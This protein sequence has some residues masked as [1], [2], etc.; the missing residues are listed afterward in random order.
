MKTL[1]SQLYGTEQ[2]LRIWSKVEALQE[3]Y[4]DLS[5]RVSKRPSLSE[6]DVVLIAYPDQVSEPGQRPLMTL[7]N[8]LAQW[9][10]R[11]V[12][13]LHLLPIHPYSSDDGFSV[14]D[15][16]TVNPEF[17]T[18][19]DVEALAA[20]YQLML[21]AVINHVSQQS[22]W[23][24]AY[25]RNESPYNQYFI[26]AN[27][28]FEV[29]QVYRARATPLLT[30]IQTSVGERRVWTSF[31][32]DQIDLNYANPEVLLEM[33]DVLLSYVRHGARWLRLDAAGLL[34]KES[35]TSCLHLPQ[36]HAVI[37][38]IRSVLDLSA[39]HVGIVPQIN[40]PWSENVPYL[41]D[42]HNE[43]QMIY[44]YALPVMV[45]HA[46]TFARSTELHEWL[47]TLSLPSDDTY[48]YNFLA[49]HDGISLRP[50]RGLI[51]E[52][53]LAQMLEAAV[54]NGGLINFRK[55]RTGQEVPYEV[56]I[57]YYDA[58][59][60][61]SLPADTAVARFRIAHAILLSISG[62]PAIYF[63]SLLGA[64][65]WHEGFLKTGINRTLNRRKYQ[66]QELDI[67]LT[68]THFYHH[69]VYSDL[70]HLIAARRIE[71]AFHPNASQ[72]ML[73]LDARILGIRR[74]RMDQSGS[75]YALHNLSSETVTWSLRSQTAGA[76]VQDLLHAT[77]F[78][79]QGHRFG[80]SLK[81]YQVR[82]LLELRT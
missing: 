57:T 27:D 14:V 67:L 10:K 70:A 82:W 71:A 15:F 78:S 40:G 9:A 73:K 54:N 56:A 29:S 37:Q 2:Q 26:E 58:L 25:K 35:G 4:R 62:V 81:P 43:A 13:A 52:P 36:T 79:A 11:L 12:S 46:L 47:S 44:H 3:R 19:R 69:R 38:L 41:G 59:N 7:R 18:W 60:A 42:G 17:G 32:H 61:K 65:S 1:V 76:H 80:G 45:W 68:D 74:D 28:A 49:C 8:V 20:E 24:A 77:S 33:L 64:R 22:A 23:F 63:Q 48:L 39:P 5:N 53:D 6:A 16:R 34:W 66:R 50:A 72:H 21:D 75:V 30:T 31:S 55:D 51:A